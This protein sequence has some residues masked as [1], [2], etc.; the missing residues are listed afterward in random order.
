MVVDSLL[1]G[2]AMATTA[3]YYLMLGRLARYERLTA[4][5]QR[6][7]VS[8]MKKSKSYAGQCT[9]EA[10]LVAAHVDA[11]R[12]PVQRVSHRLHGK[13][14]KSHVLWSLT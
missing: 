2:K 9:T 11:E 8:R 13:V 1:A 5:A 3:M 14:I 12:V 10:D 6:V 7:A 4:K